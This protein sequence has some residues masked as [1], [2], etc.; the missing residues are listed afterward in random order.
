MPPSRRKATAQQAP[1]TL[2]QAIAL[3]GH[4]RDL[5]DKVEAQDKFRQLRAW[6]AVAA[7]ELT[8]GKRKSVQLAGMLIGERTTPPA[9]KLTKGTKPQEIVDALIDQFHDEYVIISTKLDK[10]AI[11]KLLRLQLDEAATDPETLELLSHREILTEELKLSVSQKEEF[12]IDRPGKPAGPE[13]VPDEPES[14]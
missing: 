4:Y 14:A 5:V 11:I 13:V 12:F 7:P 1:Q 9:L 6:W 3:I 2:E 10:A 8:G